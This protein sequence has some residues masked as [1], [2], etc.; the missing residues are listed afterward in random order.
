MCRTVVPALLTLLAA[1]TATGRAGAHA[2]GLE[3]EVR[4]GR[5]VVQVYFDDATPARKAAVK[6]EDPDGKM[7]AEGKTDRLG[8][9]EC[10]VPPAGKYKVTAD[11]GAGHR[12]SATV[13][14][15]ATGGASQASDP[16]EHTDHPPSAADAYKVTSDR[17]TREEF[18]RFPWLKAGI[19]LGA[20]GLLTAAM[21][22]AVWRKRAGRAAAN[23]TRSVL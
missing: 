8:V 9:W 13:T 21:L 20:I 2:V 14:V 22:V 18:T 7:V 3:C 19:G 23:R 16:S 4:D 12:A 15:Q 5:L 10:P 17:Q 1:L 6:V 11:A